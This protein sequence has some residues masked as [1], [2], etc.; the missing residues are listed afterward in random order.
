MKR[1][2]HV[3][4]L[5]F[6]CIFMF[7][8]SG[9]V[10]SLSDG[11]YVMTMESDGASRSAKY[12]LKRRSVENPDEAKSRTKQSDQPELTLSAVG[13]EGRFQGKLKGNTFEASWIPGSVFGNAE[14][15]GT[16]VTADTV[17]GKFTLGSGGETTQGT[18]RLVRNDSSPK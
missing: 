15:V 18:F 17:E 8:C 7:G 11:T 9:R 13:G 16:L 5:A 4:L 14:L 1:L 12:E 3:N 2:I 6:I 10:H